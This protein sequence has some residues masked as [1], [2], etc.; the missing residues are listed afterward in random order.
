MICGCSISD[1]TVS[2]ALQCEREKSLSKPELQ[3][4]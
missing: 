2:L 3:G 1:P 4:P